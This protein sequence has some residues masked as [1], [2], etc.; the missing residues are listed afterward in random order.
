MQELRRNH[1]WSVTFR[2]VRLPRKQTITP[3]F[4]PED[5][6]AAWERCDGFWVAVE[7]L[8]VLG[9]LGVTLEFAHRQARIVDLA[10]AADQRRHGIASDLLTHAIRWLKRKE[11]K[12]VLLSCPLKAQPGH[13]FAQH[14]G[15]SICGFQDAYW[16]DQ[17]I[18]VF[19]R[20]R[21]R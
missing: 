12:Q 6:L 19:F 13:A 8:R 7:R 20:K 18:G 15:F 4:T 11:I 10:V 3:T 2:E 9:Y 5:Q 16:P 17:E 14:H 21:L 1:E